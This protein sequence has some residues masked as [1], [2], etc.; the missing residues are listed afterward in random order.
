M[1]PFRTTAWRGCSARKV[2][3]RGQLAR[4]TRALASFRYAEIQNKQGLELAEQGKTAEAVTQFETALAVFPDYPQAHY[5]LADALV[6]QG[7]LESAIA[8]YRRA[9]A[10]DPNFAPA[11]KRL[12][13]LSN[14]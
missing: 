9:L 5:N 7:E 6:S 8:H 3:D 12:E 10:I 14:R 1:S 13:Q 11:I 2:S 4:P